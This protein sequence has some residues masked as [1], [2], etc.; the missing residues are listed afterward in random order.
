VEVPEKD[1]EQNIHGG[2]KQRMF[3]VT[4]NLGTSPLVF[5]KGTGKF[6]IHVR[7]LAAAGR[8]KITGTKVDRVTGATTAAFDEYIQIDAV[9]T[10]TS[11]TDAVGN[12][13]HG[14]AG[15][16]MTAN[17]YT[18][19][20]NLRAE[21]GLDCQIDVYH[22]SF[23]QFNDCLDFEV[24]TFDMNV[25]ASASGGTLYA[26]LYTI[27]V[28]PSTNRAVIERTSSLTVPSSTSGRWYRLRR[29]GLAKELY[30]KNDGI[31]VDV[32]L[33]PGGVPRWEQLTSKVWALVKY[34]GV[35]EVNDG[36]SFVPKPPSG[37]GTIPPVSEV[38]EGS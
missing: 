18:G 29:G 28:D 19:T 13:V 32:F 17:W 37:G 1:S 15:V 7:S 5:G 4:L 33:G 10:D 16:Y 11:S 20:V 36:S 2:I 14:F 25:Y 31:W 21:A 6:F 12:P 34:S 27:D 26:Y 23:E 22:V 3:A 35:P 9:S 30:G 24:Q 38:P 8:V